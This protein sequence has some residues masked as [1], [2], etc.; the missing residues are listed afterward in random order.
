[1]V[2][3]YLL[4]IVATEGK[5]EIRTTKKYSSRKELLEQY[6][7]LIKMFSNTTYTHSKWKIFLLPKIILV[8]KKIL[9]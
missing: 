4:D 8:P 1:M 2:E 3:L 9:W 5:K 6:D 7:I